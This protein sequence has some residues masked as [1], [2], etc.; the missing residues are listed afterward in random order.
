MKQKIPVFW[1]CT[2]TH[3]YP[4]LVKS[5]TIALE[6]LGI[7]PV[8]V[9]GFGCCPDPVY[10]KA[11]GKD[12]QLALSAR[13]LALAEK[14]GKKLLVACNGCY[15][16]L[17]GASEELKDQKTREETNAMLPE[18]MRYNGT[19]EVIH[20]LNLLHSKI[21]VIK[22]MAV[23]PLRGVKAAVH[24]GCHMLYPPVVP[25]DDPRN[26]R[27]IDELVLA[28]G[29]KALD[30]ESRTDCCGVPVA[31]FDKDE[32]DGILQKKLSDIRKAEADCIVTSCPACFMRFDMLPQ[33]LKDLGVPVLHISELL[34]LAFGVPEEQLFLE[35]HATGTGPLM[36]KISE[37]ASLEK[38]LITKYFNMEELSGHCEACREECT[39]AV[40]T[41]NAENPFDP[42][43]PVDILLTGRYY[44]A[45]K[46]REIW[47]CLQCGKCE[48][49]CPNNCGLKEFYAK[50]RELSIKESGAP[51]IIDDH[52]KMLEE[53][54]YSMPKRTG[55]RKKMG[56]E[57]APDLDST[58]IRKIL[59][60]VRKKR[61]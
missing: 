9:A 21:P 1:G 56:L 12:A 16:I 24:Y 20:V 48:E 60:N 57:P 51:R 35:G 34:C 52:M 6:R 30:Y 38:T 44:D 59:D 33:E 43:A 42:L 39:A 46:S 45:V 19:V 17:H 5:I 41:R 7:E 50:L 13:N 40:S 28:T 15:N 10:V 22:T 37:A 54:G 25:G 2:F 18:G 14:S 23:R 29:A 32:A 55:I 53:T 49:R 27:S 47:R 8:E 11:Y 61:K 58:E 31:A 26:P 3:N 36:A 4:F